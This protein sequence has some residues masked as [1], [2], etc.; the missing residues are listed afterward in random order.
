MQILFDRHPL[1]N[2]RSLSDVAIEGINFN[3]ESLFG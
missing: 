1:A 2:S 3:L